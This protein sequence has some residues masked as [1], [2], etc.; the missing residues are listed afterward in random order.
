MS[1][2]RSAPPAVG[3]TWQYQLQGTVD[4]SIDARVFDIDGFTTSAATVGALHAQSRHVICYL[5]GGSWEDFRP[6]ASAFPETI[7]GKPYQGYANERWLDIRDHTVLPGLLR[8]RLQSQ[9]AKKGFDGVEW[10]NVEGFANDTGFPLT[11]E[12][13]RRFNT[14]LAR[15][16]HEAGL[17]VAL[18]NDREQVDALVSGFDYAV[19]EECL[20]YGECGKLQ[21]YVAAGKPVFDVEY[22]AAAFKCP[23]PPGVSVILKDKGLDAKPRRSC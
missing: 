6:D 18:K 11:A 10:D 1:G 15:I 12:D 2:L 7:L 19:D 20:Q 23:G 3:A 13:Q 17:R 5:D 16:T 14:W 8:S 21:P 9:C 4:T 22:V